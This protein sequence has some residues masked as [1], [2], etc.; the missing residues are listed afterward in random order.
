MRRLA[1]GVD[2]VVVMEE[3]GAHL[4]DQVRRALEGR[5]QAVWGKAF[6]G[7]ARG[8]PAGA[9]MDPDI[10]LAALSRGRGTPTSGAPR[11]PGGPSP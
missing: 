3:R 4:E 8:F 5:R 9:G 1:D 11:W 6:P 7:G 10:A 2:E